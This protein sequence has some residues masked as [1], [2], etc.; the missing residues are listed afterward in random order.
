MQ[1]ET[2]VELA[3]RLFELH[4][5]QTTELASAEYQQPTADYYDQSIAEREQRVLFRQYPLMIGLSCEIPNPGDFIVN[6]FSGVPIIVVRTEHGE[7]KAFL[8]MCRHRGARIQRESGKGLTALRCPYHAW[9]YDLNNGQ[10]LSVPFSAGF[11][12]IDKSST[13]LETLPAHE[14]D[15]LVFVCPTQQHLF[16]D[17]GSYFAPF[18]EDLAGYALPDYHHFETRILETEFNWKLV[19]DTFLETYHLSTLHRQTIAPLLYSNLNTFTALGHH[20]RMVAARK[21]LH[22]LRDLPQD[23][24]DLITHS[25]VVYVLFPNTVFIMQGDHLE[26]W[27]VYPGATPDESRMR[28]SLYTPEPATTDSARRHWKNNMDLL[29]ATVLEEDFPLT[30][31]MQQDFHVG[32][33]HIVFGKNEPALQHFH[34]TLEKSLRSDRARDPDRRSG[35]RAG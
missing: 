33:E 20:L 28:V 14:Q 34:K 23:Q 15:G 12:C 22:G 11:E 31:N 24:W 35:H 6:D 7:V 1:Q 10:L 18:A 4:E 5:A 13:S 3:T 21:T 16:N 2:Q 30:T 32:H 9:T 8:N 29:M 27:Q 17:A 26:T 25:A 19:I